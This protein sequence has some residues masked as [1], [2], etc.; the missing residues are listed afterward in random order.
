MDLKKYDY[1][2]P[3]IKFDIFDKQTKHKL[4]KELSFDVEIKD[5][6]DN[7]PLFEEPFKEV[8]VKENAPE[9]EYEVA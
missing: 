8:F 6:N 4:D 9:G 2:Y 7:K 1:F 5:I 3:Q